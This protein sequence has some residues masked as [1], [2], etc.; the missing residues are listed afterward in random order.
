M[1]PTSPLARATVRGLDRRR[2]MTEMRGAPGD[3]V[4]PRDAPGGE[5]VRYVPDRF[6]DD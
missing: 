5:Q 2:A 1:V 4:R 3:D 6:A